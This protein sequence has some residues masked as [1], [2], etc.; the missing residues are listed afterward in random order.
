MIR[1]CKDGPAFS[2]K[3]AL[4]TALAFL[5]LLLALGS[6]PA[7]ATSL[8]KAPENPECLLAKTYSIGTKFELTTST[9]AWFAV[10]GVTEVT[11]SATSARLTLTEASTPLFSEITNMVFSGCE[12]SEARPCTVKT[13]NQPLLS[14]IYKYSESGYWG[15]VL[16]VP[17]EGANPSWELLCTGGINCIYGHSEAIE[18][19]LRSGTTPV[20]EI[21]RKPLEL[22][23]G[24][25]PSTAEIDVVYV[26]ETSPIYVTD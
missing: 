13:R 6:T 24:T 18:A 20:F 12:D 5:F 11:C 4:G 1:S 9:P 14:D 10:T 15:K 26:F 8:C 25:C 7:S 3:A 19:L 23:Q 22:E 21:F 2:A 17:R 16:L